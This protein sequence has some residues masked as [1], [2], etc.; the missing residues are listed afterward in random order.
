V[1]PH[2]KTRQPLSTRQFVMET[3]IFLILRCNTPDASN[4]CGWLCYLSN[5]ILN[6]KKKMPVNCL[7]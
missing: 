3:I 4:S 5:I 2:C 1:I 6:L 7:T